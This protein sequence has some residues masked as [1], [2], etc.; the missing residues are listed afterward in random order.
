MKRL[1][2]VAAVFACALGFTGTAEAGTIPGEYIVVL[3]TGADPAAVAAEHRNKNGADVS[4]VY[5]H[6][7]KGYAARIPSD[8]LAAVRAD[9]RVSF[10]SV[11]REVQAFTHCIG[12]PQ[13]CLSEGVDRIDG[14]RSSTRS[15]NGTG[16]V[17]IDVAV[18]DTGTDADHPDLNVVGG[19]NC[20]KDGTSAVDDPDRTFGHGTHVGGIIGAIDNGIGVVGVVPGARLWS[21]RVLGPGGFGRDSWVICG[22]DWVAAT[23]TDADQSNDIEVA[24]LSLGGEGSDDGNCGRSDGDAEHLAVCNAVAAGVVIVAAA[25]NDSRD[26]SP[27]VPAAYDE[28]LTVTALA[29]YDG[30]PGGLASPT[31]HDAGADDSAAIFSNFAALAADHAH[32]VSAPGVCIRS[33]YPPD[34]V[35]KGQGTLPYLTISGTSMATP[36]AA[37]TAAL[38]IASGRCAGL[39]PRQIIA[40]I[41]GDSASYNN[42]RRNTG[43]GFQGDPLRPITG[44]YYG[45]LIRAGL[46]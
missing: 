38:C 4:F 31:C 19:V 34:S 16:A 29:D 8:Q 41:V 10:V 25:G 15:G 11:D 7:L 23:R 33:T 28:V 2:T 14:D 26:F 45:Y 18:L 46:Y 39:T 32:T 27:D 17:D 1:V 9:A 5:K 22:L 40:K 43:Y 12:V 30:R 24:N 36:H 35:P 42:A 13:Q 44:K 6:A 3:K 21:V 37:G 20:T